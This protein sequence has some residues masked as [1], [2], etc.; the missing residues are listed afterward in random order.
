[1][2]GGQNAN[3]ML[4]NRKLI[5]DVFCEVYDLLGP[6]ADDEFWDFATQEIIPGAIYVIGRKQLMDNILR[7]KKIIEDN[8]AK[9][10]FS[11]P[12]EGSETL[13]W[14]L[15]RFGIDDLAKQG[16]LL[17]IGGGDM[18]PTWTCLR[19]DSFLP[20][21]LD[22]DENIAAM[23]RSNELYTTFP[24][25]YKFLFLNGRGRS[26]RKYLIE[27]FKLSGLIDQSI[28]STLDANPGDS[29]DISLMHNGENLLAR[30]GQIQLL[31]KQYEVDRYQDN[32]NTTINESYGKYQLFNN[33]WG[34]I[35]LN[36]LPYI[37]SYF[38]VVTETVFT[39][40]YSFRTEKIW[41]PVVMCQPW[42]VVANQGFL[43]DIRNLGFQTFSSIIDESYD[44]IDDNQKRIECVAK[45]VEDLCQQDLAKFLK[46]CYTTCK[47][48]QQHLAEMRTKVRQDFP[49]QFFQ[50]V[51]QN[52]NE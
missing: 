46:E 42:I 4:E 30:P 44:Q 35:Y 21:F 1:M 20:K 25:P 15:I 26:H 32:V 9:I 12:H 13:R 24:K 41:K 48:N 43:K 5:L 36:P 22:Y 28:W 38:S 10:I 17:L 7:V 45:L 33:E 39:Y 18:D 50:F 19:F 47:Y 52:I 2:P 37:D 23:N 11:N 6:Y 8:Q 16:R 14:H 31:P 3:T 29:Q 51:K 49:D 34:E 40:P 27:R